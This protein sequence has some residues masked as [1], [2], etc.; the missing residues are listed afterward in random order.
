MAKIK[1]DLKER[2]YDVLIGTNILA[3]LG[4][5]I[6]GE[7]WGRDIFIITDPLVN[8][9]YGDALRRGLKSLKHRTLEIP[10]GERY[11]NLKIASQ[12]YDDLVKFSA[13]RDSLIIALG[14]GVIG[15]LAGFVAATYMRGINYIEVPT[16]LLAQVD[17]AIGGKTAV[18]HPKC[19]NLIG[20]FYQPKLVYIDIQTLTTLPAR[21]LRTG[22]A[23][24]VKY[25]VIEDADFFK[26]LEA[27]SHHLTT[28]AFESPDTLRASLKVWQTIVAESAKIKARVVEK[29]EREG[30]LRMILNFGHTIGHALETLTKYKA[31]NHGEAVAMGMV[32]AAKVANRRKM[33]GQE[34]V[35]RII[36]LLE[37]LGLPTE[38]ERLPSQK[39]LEAL[40]IDKKVRAGKVQFVLPER[41]GKVVVKDN[42][43]LKIVRQILKEIGCR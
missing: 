5:M 42:V 36:N 25:G 4:G 6:S 27:N 39:I 11:K 32:A 30:G 34:A 12:I 13:H 7:K 40:A 20:S 23:E 31:Y 22:L 33:I 41:I 19:K 17:A 15:D 9:L 43:P 21:E 37:K 16:T 28:K 10:R 29:D 26:F 14:G 1:V 8:D 24:V 38:I 18:N 35:A 2:S 3:D